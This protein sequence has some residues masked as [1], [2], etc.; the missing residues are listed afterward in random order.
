MSAYIRVRG[1]ALDVPN[2]VQAPG[3][4]RHFLS[5][6]AREAMSRSKREYRTLLQDIDLDAQ[7]GDRVALLGRNG[8]GKTTLL[9]LLSGAF[10]PTRGTVEV[11]GTVQSLLSLSLGFLPEA[12]VRENV[13]LRTAAMGLSMRHV[14]PL[15]GSILEFAGLAHAADH[16]LMTLSSGQRMRLGF[17]ASTCIQHDVMLLD[18]WFGAGDAEFVSRARARM[19][20]R[21]EGSSI[22][23]LA[24]HN[25]K[26]L[27]QVCNIGVVIDG[28]RIAF[29]GDLDEALAAY[30]RLYAPVPVKKA[31]AHKKAPSHQQLLELQGRLNEQKREIRK[32][33][34]LIESEKARLGNGTQVRTAGADEDGAP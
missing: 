13:F 23:V 29:K 8:A 21:V 18:E 1:A 16:R 5:E 19:S 6:L 17:A 32:Q 2:Y 10:A 31:V 12:S 22:V 34:K 24:S 33:W 3:G 15:V 7:E 25:V 20:D 30:K 14:A 27:K 9:R 4:G 26:M 11:R 28:G